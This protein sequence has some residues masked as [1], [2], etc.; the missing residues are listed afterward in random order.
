MQIFKPLIIFVMKFLYILYISSFLVAIFPGCKK[1]DYLDAVPSNALKIPATLPDFQS[2]LDNETVFNNADP[3]LGQ[4]GAD[5]WYL[6]NAQL[7]KLPLF[8]QNIYDWTSDPYPGQEMSDWDLPYRAIF[9]ANSVIVGLGNLTPTKGQQTTWNTIKGQALFHRA[10]MFH[11]LAQLFATVYD[12]ATAFTALGIPLR[13][14]A[15]VNEK[16]FRP[17]L[18][19]TYD[20]IISDLVQAVSLLPNTALY[21]TRPSK[22]T[23]YGLLARVYLSIGNYSLAKTYSDSCLTFTTATL[24]DFNMLGPTSTTSLFP[25]QRDNSEVLLDCAMAYSISPSNI[26]GIEVD[27]LL[28]NSYDT[29]DLRKGVF[30]RTS[31]YGG[32]RFSGTYNANSLPFTGIAIDEI[33][34]TRSE[35]NARLGNVSAALSDLNAVLQNRWKAGTFTA[36]STS[37][38]SDALSLILKERRKELLGRALRWTDLRRLNKDPNFALTITRYNNG[39]QYTLP[40]NDARYTWTIPSA[41]IIENPGMVQNVR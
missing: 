25:I 23:A 41:V 7:T 14:T 24:M 13:L 5:D 38:Q 40:A 28:Y 36:F 20:Q 18:K 12:S 22:S 30:F 35:C 32:F 17:S 21:K 6:S 39:Q 10:R 11:Q 19:A 15:D 3:C 29:N 33:Y 31:Y 37:N 9:Y 26:F 1:T 16:I 4:V 27:S 34:L 2:L 8:V